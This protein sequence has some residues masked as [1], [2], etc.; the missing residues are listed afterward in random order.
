MGKQIDAERERRQGAKTAAV[1]GQKQTQLRQHEE[2]RSSA[3]VNLDLAEKIYHH[4]NHHHGIGSV[5]EN[6]G[7]LYLDVGDLDNAS[8]QAA[9][10]FELG[11]E[12]N[13]SILMAR[14]RLLQCEV[15]T[16][17]W[18]KRLKA[19]RTRGNM[20]RPRATMLEKRWNRPSTRK[21]IV[22]WR[23]LTSGAGLLHVIPRFM[24]L[25]TPSA[26]ANLPARF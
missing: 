14:A 6:R 23:A 15:E 4:H 20:L 5:L 8:A 18:K 24:I 3:F 19:A 25:M 16:E 9:Q 26:A 2:L 13:D 1:R 11:K 12:V 17:N 7:L 10:A 22:C 21:I